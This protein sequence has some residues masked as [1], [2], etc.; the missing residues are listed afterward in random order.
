MTFMSEACNTLTMDKEP[1]FTLVELMIA[2]VV[3]S[4]LLASGAPAFKDFIKNNRVTSQTNGH[5]S[6]IQLARSEALKRGSNMVVCASSDQATCTGKDTWAEGWILF[7]DLNLNNAPDV[8]TGKCLETEDCI[9][10][11]RTALPEGTTLTTDAD[12]V[13]FLPTGLSGTNTSSPTT[14]CTPETGSVTSVEFVL[15]AKNCEKNQARKVTIT[16]QGHTLVS[17]V[18]CS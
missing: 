18:A 6:V 13:C 17:T 12:F 3:V 15:K 4:I 16:P 11:I 5:V 2:I 10:T 1:G 8:G 9:M 14:S 7:S